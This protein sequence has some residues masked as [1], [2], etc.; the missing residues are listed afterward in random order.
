MTGTA[1]K[2]VI[3][4][5]SPKPHDRESGL[6]YYGLRSYSPGLGR[7]ISR[8]PIGERGGPNLHS[9]IRARPVDRWDF[10]GLSDVVRGTGEGCF[11]GRRPCTINVKAFACTGPRILGPDAPPG[12][13][14]G[15]AFT[16]QWETHGSCKDVTVYVWDCGMQRN[17]PVGTGHDAWG[18]IR[19]AVSPVTVLPAIDEGSFYC[20]LFAFKSCEGSMFR[21]TWVV[22][23]QRAADYCLW[24]VGS[25]LTPPDEHVPWNGEDE[26]GPEIDL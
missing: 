26:R 19:P 23:K 20:V 12:S 15:R 21:K 6:Y 8:D 5:F 11:C 13:V 3:F 16:L 4:L 25:S 1:S 14:G 10:L 17:G 22:R 2:S 7:W 18:W 9:F 24:C